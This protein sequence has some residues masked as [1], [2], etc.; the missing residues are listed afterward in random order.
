MFRYIALAIVVLV[1]NMNITAQE[2]QTDTNREEGFVSLF[3]GKSLK[4]WKGGN[5]KYFRVQEGA[6]VAGTMKEKVPNNE[7]L[8]HKKRFADFEL[9]LKAKLI[10]EG[11]NAGIQ[12]RSRRPNKKEL[13]ATDKKK[14]L[15]PHEMSTLR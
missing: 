13:E 11:G 7:F 6:I 14:R 9:R 5:M 1:S 8:T 15:P 4:G 2:T 10:G 12:I 3:D